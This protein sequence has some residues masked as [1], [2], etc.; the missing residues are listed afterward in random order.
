M[1]KYMLGRTKIFNR[2]VLGFRARLVVLIWLLCSKVLSGCAAAVTPGDDLTAA[3]DPRWGEDTLTERLAD[4][5]SEGGYLQLC[6]ENMP[7]CK[8]IGRGARAVFSPS[9]SH[10]GTAPRSISENNRE[11]T[12]TENEASKKEINKDSS[13]KWRVEG[14]VVFRSGV[15]RKNLLLTAFGDMSTQEVRTNLNGEFEI[16]TPGTTHCVTKI[17]ID[18]DAKWKGRACPRDKPIIVVDEEN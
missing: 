2:I 17:F 3:N 8:A 9:S 15:P 11:Q 6:L 10:V 5:P 12:S 13:G 1:T 7:A 4:E 14:K 18:G 16:V